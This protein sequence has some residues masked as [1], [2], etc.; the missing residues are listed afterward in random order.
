MKIK[1]ITTFLEEYAPLSLQEPYDNSGLLI[2]TESQTISKALITLDVTDAVMDEAITEKCNLIIAHHPL[3]FKDIKSLTG[4]NYVE[5]LIVKAIKNDIS[6]YAIHTNLDN[7]WKGVNGMLAEKL[8][9][10]NT[11]ILSVNDKGLKKLVTFCPVEHA[12]KVRK[13]MFD[14]G[15]GYIGNYDNCSYNITGEG[16]FRGMEGTEPFVG[17]K[18]ALHFEKEIRIETI[19]PDYKTGKVI[20]AMLAA[21]P[22]EEV[23]YDI[24]SLDNSDARIGAGMIG[25]LQK[26]TDPVTFLKHIKSILNSKI[27]KHSPPVDRKIKRIAICGGSGSFL[28]HRAFSAGADIFITGDVKYHD[29]FEYNGQMIIADAGH[30]ETEQF[31]KELLHTVLKEKFPTFALLISQAVTNPVNII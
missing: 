1:D 24:Y 16:T 11:K 9:L 30:Y 5:K 19:V 10:T 28:I 31:T 3:I 2:G 8:G 4:K 13:A 14:A 29:F 12:N 22:Y 6:I 20:Q 7:V 23:A 21:H 17:K 27:I 26:E 18:G 25:E 15:A